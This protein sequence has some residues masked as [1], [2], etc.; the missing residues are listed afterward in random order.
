MNCLKLAN[1][2]ILLFILTGCGGTKLL[3]EPDLFVATQPLVTDSNESLSVTLDWVIYR[4]GPGT[5]ARN[6]D[7]D[8]YLIRVESMAD[9][10]IQ[11]KSIH[12]VDSLDTL[13]APGNTRKE[14][15][16]GAKQTK[17]RYSNYGLKVK[18]GA[19]AGVLLAAGAVTAASVA[20]AGAAVVYGS[21]A[22]A[23]G[24]ATGV[25]LV[26]AFAVGGIVRGVN[27][28]KVSNQIEIRQ[29]H[30]P[31]DVLV[32]EE[33]SLHIFYPLA[34]SPKQIELTYVDSNGEHKLIIDT[35][36]SLDGL[37]L[38]NHQAD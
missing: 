6:A 12:I 9:E 37:H 16:K 22:V 8:E 25:L 28:S 19:S 30:L 32:G 1:T 5:W 26:P 10:D 3:K 17:K 27:N 31:T 33:K 29:T 15:V 24:A 4:D 13:I 20:S 21:T 36:K 14:L 23:A 34:P 7:W 11:I 2:F 18:A 38:T 35:M